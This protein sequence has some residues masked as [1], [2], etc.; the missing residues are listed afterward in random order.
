MGGKVRWGGMWRA[1]GEGDSGMIYIV[2][3]VVGGT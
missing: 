3:Y 2:S 1:C